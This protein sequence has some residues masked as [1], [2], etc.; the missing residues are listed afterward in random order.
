[1]RKKYLKYLCFAAVSTILLANTPNVLAED[2]TVFY[3][4]E[5]KGIQHIYDYSDSTQVEILVKPLYIT[6]IALHEGEE[7]TS[8]TAGDTSRF[9]VDTDI[10]NDVP[11]VYVKATQYGIQTNMV[12]NTN[13]RSYRFLVT[14]SDEAEYYVSFNYPDT[15][16]DSVK[17]VKA[18]TD[19][20]S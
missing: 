15:V 8:I 1:M 13:A 7:I 3:P 11:H 20:T 6:D 17:A 4:K 2:G 14:S 12:I 18:A 5:S 9:M 16:P 10:V 19:S